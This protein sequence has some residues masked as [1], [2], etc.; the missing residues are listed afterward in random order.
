MRI[1]VAP[2]AFKGSIDVIETCIA[3]VKGIRSLYPDADII[4]FP[5]SDGGDGFLES[6]LFNCGGEFIDAVVT[7]PLGR[8]R[9]TVC[10]LL[11]DG[12]GIVEMA[13][14]SGIALLSE[15]EKNPFL[16]TSYGTGELIDI[17]VKRGARKIIVGVGGSATI[18]MGVGCMQALGVR[19]LDEIGKEVGY[20]GRELARIRTI[21]I[22]KAKKKLEDLKLAIAA[23]VR[24]ILLGE[25]G[26]VYTYGVQKGLS[27]ADMPFMEEAIK[28]VAEI[29]KN[30]FGKDVTTIIGGG[31][32]GG[33][34]AG[35]YGIMNAEIN[36]G[37]E[38]L[39]EM[40]GFGEKVKGA[41]L[42]ITGEGRVDRQT[43][44]GKVV[45]KVLELGRLNDIFVLVLSGEITEEGKELFEEGYSMGFCINPQ[46]LLQSREMKT[47]GELLQNGTVKALKKL[48]LFPL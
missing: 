33:I 26:A 27:C 21:D 43:G 37:I 36:N 12:T 45:K 8:K 44:Y 41:D 6:L 18:D 2:T 7:G 9:K 29:I 15:D 39:F 34:A 32:A 48:S 25:K 35:L 11:K 22:G 42:V 40:I 31:A 3:I 17:L 14:P 10:G 23:D 24:N 28:N 19:F 13:K 16:T 46:G 38:F 30:E 20:G 4:Q 1:V 47:T 5:I